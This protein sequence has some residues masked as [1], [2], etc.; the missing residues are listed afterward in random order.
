[1]KTE[2][3]EFLTACDLAAASLGA[4][5]D[6]GAIEVVRYCGLRLAEAAKAEGRREMM[7]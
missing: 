2:M 1:M 5:D 6:L 7:Q 4:F 3:H